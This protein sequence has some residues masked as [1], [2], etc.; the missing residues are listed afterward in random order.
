MP[1]LHESRA[2]LRISGDTLVP[3]EVS[4]LLGISPT[5]GKLKG[6]AWIGKSSG[7]KYVAKTGAWHLDADVCK[8]GDLDRQVADILDKLTGDLDVWRELTRKFR[9]DL[10]CGWFMDGT[11]EGLSISPRT[12]AAL[13]ER[14]IE[15][16]I[17]L[18]APSSSDDEHQAGKNE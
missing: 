13:A 12:M 8:P 18:Y 16:G 3:Q 5:S 15:L 1:Q 17:C 11:D 7:R 2:G 9:V 14:G 4:G 10:F 6:E